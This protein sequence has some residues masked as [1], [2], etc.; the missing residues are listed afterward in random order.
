VE[1]IISQVK[2]SK[3][4]PLRRLINGLSFPGIGKKL[5]KEVE[6]AMQEISPPDKCVVP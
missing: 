3:T 6:K 4:Q 1:Q 2:K 5:A